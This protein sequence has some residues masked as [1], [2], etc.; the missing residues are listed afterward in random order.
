MEEIMMEL[1][2]KC[3]LYMNPTHEEIDEI[4]FGT[5]RLLK[6][7]MDLFALTINYTNRVVSN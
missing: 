5:N 1:T 6:L 4:R 7:E 2:I 3:N